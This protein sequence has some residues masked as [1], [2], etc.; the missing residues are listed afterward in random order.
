MLWQTRAS[1]PYGVAGFAHGSIDS[2][3]VIAGGTRWENDSKITLTDR[4]RYD[5]STDTW[6]EE[7]P[8]SRPFAFG[9]FGVHG[10]RLVLL[11]G[12]DGERTR[13]DGLGGVTDR[14]LPDS[15]AYAG[16][17]I[18]S[19]KI[20]VLGGTAD[21]RN[22]ARSTDHFFC[23][24]LTTGKAESLPAFPDG[25]VIHAALVA[26]GDNLFAFTGGHWDASAQKLVNTAAAW[27]Y[28]PI[29]RAW[30]PL[31]NYPRATR[32][33]G[34]QIVDARYVLLAGGDANPGVTG[35]CFLYDTKEN[36]Y[37]ALPPL[38]VSAMLIGLINDGEFLYAA[39]GEDRARHRSVAFYRAS[40][41]QILATAGIRP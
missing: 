23:I 9:P 22:L 16:S 21:L 20:Y 19:G 39:G 15:V 26:L 12:D 18:L 28:S 31:A 37:S 29:R 6:N 24:D 35:D 38:P 17:A 11:G 25:P 2:H 27:C 1:L 5:A 3:P 34:A 10:G 40:I 7:P 33:L 32:G 4:R 14:A 36:R 41:R 13:A 8:L 30:V